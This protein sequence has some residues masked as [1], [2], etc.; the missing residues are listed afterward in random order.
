[1]KLEN[2]DSLYSL[3]EAFPTE[4]ACIEHLEKLRWPC[5]IVCQWC[6]CSRKF[7]K[8]RMRRIN[9]LKNPPNP[10][11]PCSKCAHFDFLAGDWPVHGLVYRFLEEYHTR[12]GWWKP[13]DIG[14]NGDWGKLPV[15][16]QGNAEQ[17][18]TNERSRP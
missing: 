8:N 12:S 14:A 5:G 18:L 11:N 4:E 6:G 10:A 7:Y 16:S 1:M 17:L 2:Y 13:F 15:T 9:G 3:M